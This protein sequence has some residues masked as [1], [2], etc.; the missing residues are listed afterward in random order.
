MGRGLVGDPLTRVALVVAACLLAQAA[1][2]K[3]LLD[4]RLDPVGQLAAMW[5]YL[6][7]AWSGDRRRRT[8]HLAM[9]AAVAVTAGVLVLYGLG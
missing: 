4:V 9:A 3:N 5:V 1:I 8:E 7:F 6:A 2:A